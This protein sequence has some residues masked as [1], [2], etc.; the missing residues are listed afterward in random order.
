MGCPTYLDKHFR[1]LRERVQRYK[2]P[3]MFRKVNETE[4]LSMYVRQREKQ[5]Q[6]MDP[7][8]SLRRGSTFEHVPVTHE[9]V[10]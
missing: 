4:T 8:K 10:Y 6:E 1:E 3:L 5:G 7:H 2:R 9:N